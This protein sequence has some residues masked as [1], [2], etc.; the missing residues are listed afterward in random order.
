M[1]PAIATSMVDN[2]AWSRTNS[3]PTMIYSAYYDAVKQQIRYMWGSM[4]ASASLELAVS[5]HRK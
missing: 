3:K 4:G 2:G 1:S 5:A